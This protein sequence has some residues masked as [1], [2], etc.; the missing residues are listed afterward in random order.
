VLYVMVLSVCNENTVE[1]SLRIYNLT[2]TLVTG[3]FYV[4]AGVQYFIVVDGNKGKLLG[5]S[6]FVRR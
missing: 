1:K 5:K 2:D 6:R 3:E 4:V